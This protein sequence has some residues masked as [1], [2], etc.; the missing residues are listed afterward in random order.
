MRAGF[1]EL[2]DCPT[3]TNIIEY[4]E[5]DDIPT[6]GKRPRPAEHTYIAP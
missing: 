2:G 1:M 6:M 3:E 4:R 5:G